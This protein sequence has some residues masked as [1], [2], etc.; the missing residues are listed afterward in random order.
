MKKKTRWIVS[1]AAGAV[2]LPAGYAAGVLLGQEN[3]I[4]RFLALA[5][6][7]ALTP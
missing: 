2:A 6:A 7:L 3:P 5:N 4:G 1:I